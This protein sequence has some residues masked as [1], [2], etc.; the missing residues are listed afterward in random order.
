M[1]ALIVELL[2]APMVALMVPATP[3][4]STAPVQISRQPLV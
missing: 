4:A 2:V 3:T 1:V